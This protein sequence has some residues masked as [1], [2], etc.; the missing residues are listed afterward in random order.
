LIF[1][2]TDLFL[3]LSE[4]VETMQALRWH[5]Q[6]DVRLDE[7]PDPEITNGDDVIIEVEFCGI[8]GTDI[9]EFTDGPQMIREAAHPLTSLRPPITLGHEFSGF[10]SQIGSDISDI[11]IGQLVTVDPCLYCGQCPS[12]LRG[13][14][15]I[16]T[17]GGSV[18][19]ASD[20]ALATYVKVQRKNVIPV[21]DGIPADWA[22][23]AEPL[24]VGYHA[25]RRARIKA[26]D[27]VLITG[28]GPIG[29]ASL[30]S[31][32]ALGAS[33]VFVSEPSSERSKLAKSLGATA[34]FSPQESDVRRQ[35]YE[36]TGKVGPDA[37]IEATGRADAFELAFTSLRRG[38]RISVAGIS[39]SKL[40]VS[41]HQLVLYER[42]ILGS[43]GYNLDIQRVLELMAEGLLDPS[44]F[45]TAKFSLSQS[46]RLF[47]ESALG[48]STHLKTLLTPKE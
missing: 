10:V 26:G 1:T 36:L 4:G 32:L 30:L 12:C 33:A 22:A 41:L 28:A 48:K 15:H 45:V 47:A 39:D 25:A 9:H 43:L 11:H 19:L 14:Y 38:G 17:S 37:S 46:P 27:Q 7:V 20:G 42:E 35:V 5:G 2:D 13:D 3:V 16:C 40:T 21:P 34:V 23:V 6:N 8:C 31:A 24:A 18:G 29:I 44:P